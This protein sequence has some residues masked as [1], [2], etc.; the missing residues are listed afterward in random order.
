MSLLVRDVADLPLAVV[1]ACDHA[2]ISVFCAG[3]VPRVIVGVPFLSAVRV[4]YSLN[5]S[6]ASSP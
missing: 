1:L 4:L 3:D 2:S 5:P 6:L